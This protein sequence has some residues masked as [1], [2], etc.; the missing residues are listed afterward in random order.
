MML[1]KSLASAKLPHVL[2]YGLGAYATGS[3]TAAAL[4][5]AKLGYHVVVTDRKTAEQ[6]NPKTVRQ[7][8]RYR[9]VRLVL[10]KHRQQDIQRADLVVRNPG[11][12]TEFNKPTTND[13]DIFIRTVHELYGDQVKLIGITG[14]RGKSTT[15]A[16]IGHILKAK[17]GSKRVH[18]GGNIGMS[19][20]FFL[21]KIKRGDIVVLEL[22]SWLLRDMQQTA[23][24]VAVVTNLL[25]DH[26]N[27]YSNMALYQKDK[28]R[29][30]LGQTDAHY[31]IV[32]RADRRVQRMAKRTKAQVIQFGPKTVTGTQLLG[33]HNRFNIGAAWQVGKL[34]GLTDA[35]LKAA[36]RAFAPLAN[37][38]ETIRAY[39]DRTFINDTTATTPDATIAALLSFK[40]KV[41][42]I[43]G[44]NTKRLSLTALK[45][46]IPQRV[47]HLILLPGN[48]LHE[49]PK[50]IEVSTM[51]Q[52]VDTAW[53]LSK[54]GDVILLSPGVTWLPVMNE[55]ERGRQFVQSVRALR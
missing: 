9:N 11:V 27:Y 17:Y 50:G 13:V 40:R 24:D 55:F 21:S 54:P 7:L 25:R 38:L 34:F 5:Y 1:K 26:M 32:N 39:K 30:F 10:G 29:I 6:L 12:A 49:F 52:A 48:T 20:L 15:T 44:G 28:E 35:E 33:E 19:P 16:L 22:S 46:L 53:N 8:K 36:I 45:R 18:I 14:T 31:A 23:L 43:A 47:K 51:Q 4:F 42:L 37:R 3:G 41:I 2:I